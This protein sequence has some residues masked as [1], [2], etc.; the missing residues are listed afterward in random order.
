MLK[1]IAEILKLKNDLR[2]EQKLPGRCAF[3]D[4]GHILAYPHP[5]GNARY[6]ADVNLHVLFLWE[7]NR[8]TV[9]RPYRSRE[10]RNTWE[11]APNALSCIHRKR[12]S[13]F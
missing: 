7:R 4:E 1:Q 8:K 12:R 10:W 6:P 2:E 3:L 11:I 9:F 5:D 13:T